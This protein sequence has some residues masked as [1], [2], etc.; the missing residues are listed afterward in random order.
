MGRF[1][2]DEQERLL[3]VL[4]RQF[5]R[6][7]IIDEGDQLELQIG[8][9]INGRAWRLHVVR[10]GSTGLHSIPGVPSYLGWSGPEA[11]SVLMGI[12]NG[13]TAVSLAQ[14]TKQVS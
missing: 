8:S 6:H 2:K 10:P 14:D 5:L 4:H 12:L 1:T 7:G 13:I 9:A 3:W 11:Y